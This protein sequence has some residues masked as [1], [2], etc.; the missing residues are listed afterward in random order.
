M[1]LCDICLDCDTVVELRAEAKSA[2]QRG[3]EM[4][5]AFHDV[6]VNQRDNAWRTIERLEAEIER[7][8]SELSGE[9]V[10]FNLMRVVV[11]HT[12]DARRIERALDKGAAV[13][14][15]AWGGGEY[16]D[17]DAWEKREEIPDIDKEVE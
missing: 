11:A 15:R 12:R 16:F 17:V 14:V 1:A 10:R 3:L 4:N 6:A 13:L 9:K 2:F 7:L 8:K 5:K